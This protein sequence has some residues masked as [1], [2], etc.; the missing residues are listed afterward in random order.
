[1]KNYSHNR[2]GKKIKSISNL[3]SDMSIKR[4]LLCVTQG[5]TDPGGL[6]MLVVLFC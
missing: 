6:V 1:M 5:L 4:I 2:R 3:E